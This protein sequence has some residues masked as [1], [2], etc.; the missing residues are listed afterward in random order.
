MFVLGSKKKIKNI[1][2]A[3]IEKKKTK[4]ERKMTHERSQIS[5]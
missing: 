5:I 1:K 2:N 3:F 4:Y